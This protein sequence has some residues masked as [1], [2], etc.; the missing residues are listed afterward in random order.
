MGS[1]EQIVSQD[2]LY[3]IKNFEKIGAGACANLYKN[4]KDIN[5]K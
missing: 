4:G 2:E 1:I 5:N 3:K